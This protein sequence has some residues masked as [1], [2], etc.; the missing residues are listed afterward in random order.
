MIRLRSPD[1]IDDRIVAWLNEAYAYASMKRNHGLPHKTAIAQSAPS[2]ADNLVHSV[3]RMGCEVHHPPLRSRHTVGA[4]KPH[5]GNFISPSVLP[6]L[7]R[8]ST[9]Q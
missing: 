3:G 4:S 9:R 2:P 7:D 5:V 8:R 1:E 6:L